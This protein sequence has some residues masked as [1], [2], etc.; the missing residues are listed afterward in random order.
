MNINIRMTTA[1]RLFMLIIGVATSLLVS[2]KQRDTI[3]T[4][5][6]MMPKA[7]TVHNN[8]FV[9]NHGRQV[10]L[11]GINVVNKSK[12]QGYLVSEDST[13][14]SKLRSWGFNTIRFGIIWAG[15]EPEPGVYNEEYLKGI[16]QHIQW[17][18]NNDIFV[19]LYMHQDLYSVLYGSGAPRWATLHENKYHKTG[20]VWSDTYFMSEAV[21]TSFDNFWANALASDSIGL[22]DHYAQLWQHIA[23]RYANTPTVIGYDLMSEP[24]A[25]SSALQA[26][27]TLLTAYGEMMYDTTGKE[28]SRQELELMWSNIEE[29]TKALKDVSTAQ[30]FE[31]VVDVLF[32]LNREFEAHKLQPF[33]QKVSDAIRE[34]DGLTALFLEHSYLSNIGVRSSIARTTLVDGSH[35]SLLVYAPHGYDLVRDAE[36]ASDASPERISFIYNRIEETA[37]RLNMPAWLGEWGAF[38]R[39][40]ENVVPIAQHAMKQIETHLFGNAYW[41]YESKMDK[42]LYFK[43][44]LLRP[45]PAYTNGELVAYSYDRANKTFTMTWQED[46]TNDAPSLVFVPSI[47]TDAIKAIKKS[48]DATIVSIP[49]SSAGWLVVAPLM[50][51]EKRKLTIRL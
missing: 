1:L 23:K 48:F 9:D 32:P 22:Q 38:Y 41:S 35:D 33:Y 43:Q 45:Y 17:A 19:V 18:A 4:V 39:H 36:D 51:G 2:C 46:E 30:S 20:D 34:V 42:L 12:E 50:S 25:G 13:L 44:A 14:Y 40:D 3:D 28:L 16:D 5:E 8:K 15:L 31:S 10:I 29:R 6:A 11:N 37:Q 47:A 49:N 24:F 26:I 27:P 7:I 21:Q